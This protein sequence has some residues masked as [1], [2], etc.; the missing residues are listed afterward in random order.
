MSD[1]DTNL[2]NSV[3]FATGQRSP[4]MEA[5]QEI[6]TT[7]LGSLIVEDCLV[8]LRRVP[9]NSADLVVT[10]PPYDGQ[11]KYRNVEKYERDWYED[12]FLAVT[13]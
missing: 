1:G 12:T 5:T 11:S 9:A 4:R 10:S 6:F 3:V 2:D 13:A 8:A 7:A